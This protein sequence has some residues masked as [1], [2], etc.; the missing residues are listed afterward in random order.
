M[1]KLLFLGY[2]DI[3]QRRVLQ[4]TKG[5]AHI[6]C[7]AI[8]SQSRRNALCTNEPGTK[9]FSDYGTALREFTPDIVYVSLVNADHSQWVSESLNAG[10]HVI[11]DKPAFQTVKEAINLVNL[12]RDRGLMLAE[13][14]VYA[15]HPQIATIKR[16]F[17]DSGSCIRHISIQFTIPPLDP[18]NFR[19]QPSLGG[20]ALLDLGPYAV[21]VG[22]LFYDS[23]PTEIFCS[24]A[25]SHE[26]IE[27]ETAFS[28]LATYPQGETVTGHFDFNGEY[29][30][31]LTAIGPELSV[32]LKRLFTNPS[33]LEN[34][35]LC[36]RNNK[37]ENLIVPQADTFK[38][39]FE[40]VID[41]II[42][43]RYEPYATN[44]LADARARE[45]L[46]HSSMV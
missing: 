2:S 23:Y 39:F 10:A 34:V 31:Q 14:L 29:T 45:Q 32:R 3:V 26:H 44:L 13:A 4:A 22:R 37:S 36:R 24:V 16:C 8:A 6:D 42:C 33:D 28:M 46:I 17:S 12:S 43:K 38:I 35:I 21:S 27:V 20:G 5:I 11:V 19:Y 25:K 41:A 1:F 18:G 9:Y 40:Q 30:N 15:V 7:Y